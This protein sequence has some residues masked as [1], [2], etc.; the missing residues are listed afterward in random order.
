MKRVSRHFG[1]HEFA[2]LCGCGF[3]TVDVELLE[4]LENIRQQLNAP[5][6]INSGCRCRTHNLEVE[7]SKKSQHLRGRA[8]DIKVHGVLP[9]AVQNFIDSTWPHQYGLGVTRH[10]HI[11][12]PA[13]ARLGGAGENPGAGSEEFLRPSTRIGPPWIHGLY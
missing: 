10:L 3:D 11:S 6:T 8:A 5:V 2:C 13:L 4:I 9:Q 12:I 1:R 7:G